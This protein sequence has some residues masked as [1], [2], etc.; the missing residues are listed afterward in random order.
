MIGGDGNDVDD[1]ADNMTGGDGDDEVA[2]LA[3]SSTGRRA[4]PTAS[5]RMSALFSGLRSRT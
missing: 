2:T 1:G 3:T 4:E 5:N